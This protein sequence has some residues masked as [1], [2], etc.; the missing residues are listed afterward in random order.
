MSIGPRGTADA[1]RPLS[2]TGMQTLPRSY[3]TPVKTVGENQDYFTVAYQNEMND[4]GRPSPTCSVA[5]NEKLNAHREVCL[6]KDRRGLAPDATRLFNRPSRLVSTRCGL[7]RTGDV[8]N[9]E[10]WALL[11]RSRV[12]S[13]KS[14]SGKQRLETDR[15][16]LP[17]RLLAEDKV[18]RMLSYWLVRNLTLRI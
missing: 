2:T 17:D 3:E 16:T 18:L 13:S 8:R 5:Q 1:N 6:D 11:N 4:T 9:R 14:V 12:H 7:G 15:L 10:K